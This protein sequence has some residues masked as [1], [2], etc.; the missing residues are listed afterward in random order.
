MSPREAAVARRLPKVKTVIPMHFGTFPPLIGRP[1][2]LRD[3]SPGVEIRE[4]QPGKPVD[5]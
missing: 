1:N 3:L 2:Q 4:L 5:W